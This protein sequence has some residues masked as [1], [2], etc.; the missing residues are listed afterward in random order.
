LHR[1]DH[2]VRT[3]QRGRLAAYNVRPRRRVGL[4]EDVRLDP[5]LPLDLPELDV[6]ATARC[7]HVLEVANTVQRAVAGV[8]LQLD[9]LERLDV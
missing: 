3:K 6:R 8:H 7:R 2:E 4:N 9:L 1:S 5:P